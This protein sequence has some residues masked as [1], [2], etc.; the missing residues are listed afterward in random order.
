MPHIKSI[1]LA[2]VYFNNATQFYDDFI[3]KLERNTIYDLEMAA[4]NLL[5]QML[6][7]TVLPKSHL[8][9]ENRSA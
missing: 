5:L 9:K 7:Q 8:H 3:M 1:R 2:N 6:L 4:A